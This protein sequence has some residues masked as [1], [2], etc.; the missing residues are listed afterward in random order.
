MTL[1]IIAALNTKRV[2]GKNGKIPWHIPEDLKR[3]KA[4]TA[5]HTVL[6]GRKTFESIGSPLPFRRNI[7]VSKNN[8]FRI[9]SDVLHQ[10]T[11]VEIFHSI[12]S[13]LTATQPDEKVFV[14]GGGEI[15]RQLIGQADEMMLT[16]VDNDA[17][18]DIFFPE[19]ERMIE[20]HFIEESQT[21][22]TDHTFYHYRKA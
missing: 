17:D 9:P 22:C 8:S 13:A 21:V 12:A 5:G 7:V 10:N 11:T 20:A 15:F 1:I 18:G 3:F 6:M 4:L 16:L 19:Y 14:I 2:I